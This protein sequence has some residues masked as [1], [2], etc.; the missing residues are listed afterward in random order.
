MTRAEEKEIIKAFA[1]GFSAKQ[2]AE[3]CE[4]SLAEAAEFEKAHAAEIEMKRSEA[5]E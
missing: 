5:N 1:Y 3:E 2:V 4:I